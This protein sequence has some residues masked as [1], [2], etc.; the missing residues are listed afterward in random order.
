[1][2]VLRN[3]N[4]PV[5]A[6]VTWQVCIAANHPRLGAASHRGIKVNDLSKC[7]NASISAASAVDANWLI[8]NFRQPEFKLFLHGHYAVMGLQLPTAIATAIVLNA[9]GDSSVSGDRVGREQGYWPI[10]LSKTLASALI[11]SVPSAMTSSRI[12]RAPSSSPISI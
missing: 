6:N 10:R 12:S 1:M 11:S 4:S 3:R 7:V 9:A 8:C 2:K 5:D